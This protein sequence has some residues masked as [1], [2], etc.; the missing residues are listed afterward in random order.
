MRGPI[1]LRHVLM[2]AICCS[3]VFAE[4]PEPETFA[5]P[6]DAVVAIVQAAKTG[7]TQ[8]LLQVFGNGGAK[9]IFSGDAAVDEYSREVFLA[10]YDER[11]YVVESPSAA[12]LYIG[13]EEWPFPVP[14]VKEGEA[15]HFDTAAGA[16]EI[17]R[18][19][20]GRNELNTILV[21]QAYVQ[22]QREYASLGHDGNPAGAYALRIASTPG[23]H[24]GL[25][26][27]SDDPKDLSPL[28]EFAAEASSDEK[29]GGSDERLS[30]FHGYLF[31]IA[32][33]P[34]DPRRE[35]VAL[36]AH[37]A[38]YGVSGVMTF[39]A[40]QDGRVYQK[41]L[42]PDTAQAAA[43]VF[44]FPAGIRLAQDQSALRRAPVFSR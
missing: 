27:K 11:A 23:M 18:R 42:G 6:E 12:T 22:A 2:A 38:V 13:N 34:R 7:D 33:A 3:P 5:S 20:I 32:T 8:S 28:G 29:R 41:D 19:R 9:V 31:R 15:W 4:S 16:E 10:A 43:Q 37:P 14:L 25:Y 44:P 21:C 17:T 1:L 26:W 35:D 40:T 36:I 24:D 30:P 39:I